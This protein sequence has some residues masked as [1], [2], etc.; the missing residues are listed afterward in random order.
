MN[1]ILKFLTMALFFGFIFIV[2]ITTLS[3]P[4]KKINE[5]ENK[6]LT[7]LPRLS[8]DNITSKKF[9]TEFDKYTADQFPLRS[10]FLEIKNSY[11]YFLGQ[12][13]F[14]DIYINNDDRLME[15]FTFN[16]SIID[17]NISQVINL[18]K[19]LDSIY[20]I[21]STLMVIPTSIAFYGESIPYWAINDDQKPVV[22]YISSETKELDFLN[23]YSPYDVLKENK[24]KYIYFNTDHHWTQLGAKLA[25]EDMFNTTVEGNPT[26]VSDDFYG[27]YYSK[28]LLPNLKSDTIVAYEDYNNF[29]IEMDFDKNYDTLYDK[30][31]LQGKNKYQYFLHG[32]PAFA[33]IEGNP[34]AKDEVIIFK[35]SY[36]HSF[37][38]FLTKDFKKIHVVDPR[39][40]N[41]DLKDYLS[42]NKDIA[43]AIFMSN[44]QTINTSDFYNISP[45][46]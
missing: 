1:N 19:N 2:P 26:K 6:I 14:R 46:I 21:N 27:T 30:D 24:D 12:R 22:D 35:D 37:I 42:K 28:A 25:Y 9:M 10:E 4:D 3:T 44:I 34:S 31:K 40:Y 32:D 39:Y 36:A 33:V 41:I 7:Q 20:N 8:W 18:T 17:K 29:K 43:Q 13:E 45:T 15:K 23:F 5:I 38:P 11:S 16:K